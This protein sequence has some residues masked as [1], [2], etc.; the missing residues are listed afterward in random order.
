MI[1][2]TEAGVFF[3]NSTTSEICYPSNGG[4]FQVKFIKKAFKY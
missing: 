2:N 1:L 3:N 4:E